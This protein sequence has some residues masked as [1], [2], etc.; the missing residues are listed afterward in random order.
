MAIGEELGELLGRQAV[1]ALGIRPG[2]AESYGKAAIVGEDGELEHAAAIL[3]PRLGKP[4]RDA[5]EKGAALV[6][7]AKK[8][9]GLGTPIDVPLGHKDA[10]FV[11]SHFD[12]IEVRLPDAPR[13][14]EILVA[15]AVTDSGGAALAVAMLT[16]ACSIPHAAADNVSDPKRWCDDATKLVA[17]KSILELIDRMAGDSNGWLEKSVAAQYLA[18]LSPVLSRAGKNLSSD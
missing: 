2:E 10:A 8:M 3:H 11:R 7:S 1:A 17:D 4:L 16:L 18:G 14:D 9:G 15:V 5:V 13:S 12:A 6:P